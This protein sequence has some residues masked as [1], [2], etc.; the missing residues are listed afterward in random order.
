MQ[1]P[2]VQIADVIIP[3]GLEPHLISSYLDQMRILSRYTMDPVKG[4]AVQMLPA[5]Q[6]WQEPVPSEGSSNSK[7][8]G[9]AHPPA[10]HGYLAS[11]CLTRKLSHN[12]HISYW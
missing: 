11:D 9:A 8:S 5:I 2:R 3:K 12:G 1:G 7:S 6:E 4:P 10:T